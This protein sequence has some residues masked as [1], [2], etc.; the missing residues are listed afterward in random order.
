MAHVGIERSDQPN[1]PERIIRVDPPE[2]AG[3]WRTAGSW[4][5]TLRNP[6]QFRSDTNLLAP[7]V[8]PRQNRAVVRVHLESSTTLVDTERSLGVDIAGRER[9]R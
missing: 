3:K 6:P 9:A 8:K 5:S 7:I 4:I 2:V 1:D